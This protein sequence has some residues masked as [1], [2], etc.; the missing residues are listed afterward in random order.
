MSEQPDLELQH[1]GSGMR[2][3][4][5]GVEHSDLQPHIGAQTT[6]CAL[7]ASFHGP[8]RQELR[9]S[10]PGCPCDACRS[11]QAWW[12]AGAWILAHRPAAVVV[13]TACNP[14]HGSAPGN[15]ISCADG[16][17]G[18][19]AFFQRMFCKARVRERRA[20]GEAC[21]VLSL[22]VLR[23][24]SASARSSCAASL[25]PSGLERLFQ[26]RRADCG[27]AARAGAVGVWPGRGVA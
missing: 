26:P 3:A 17:D 7:L 24:R 2:V 10:L 19:E 5:F 25:C 13:E 6:E 4:V 14:E 8:W 1:A 11:R 12:H 16:V 21:L 22:V 15:L 9:V 18:P 23:P 27:L 20:R